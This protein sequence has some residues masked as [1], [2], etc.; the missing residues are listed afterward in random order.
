MVLLIIVVCRHSFV[1]TS[2]V[3]IHVHPARRGGTPPRG[4]KQAVCRRRVVRAARVAV[5]LS[6][7]A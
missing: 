4:G 1:L 5:A 3:G 2:P 7:L 6:V